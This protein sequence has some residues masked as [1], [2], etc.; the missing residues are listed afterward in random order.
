[1]R[2]GVDGEPRSPEERIRSRSG[3]PVDQAL[4]PIADGDRYE[5]FYGSSRRSA[6]RARGRLN[7][8]AVDGR[9]YAFPKPGDPLKSILVSWRMSASRHQASFGNSVARARPHSA[10]GGV[11]GGTPM[12][13]RPWNKGLLVGQ[14]TPLEPKHVLSIRV[15]QEI[16]QSTFSS[17]S[18]PSTASSRSCVTLIMRASGAA[19]RM[20]F[21]APSPEARNRAGGRTSNPNLGGCPSHH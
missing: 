6:W 9:N 21:A 1:M 13:A 14:K 4:A 12:I 8:R 20:Y 15:R 18:E 10:K 17:L 16:A 11:A 5:C 3:Y 7:G 2:T 19:F